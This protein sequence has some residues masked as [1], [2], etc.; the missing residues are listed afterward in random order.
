MS[1][2]LEVGLELK[3]DANG[4]WLCFAD[5]P[6]DAVV[7]DHFA[8]GLLSVFLAVG[9]RL[10]NLATAVTRGSTCRASG[11]QERT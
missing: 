2:V 11:Q 8:A 3:I 9:N 7:T 6:I 10:E 4:K 1:R 5:R